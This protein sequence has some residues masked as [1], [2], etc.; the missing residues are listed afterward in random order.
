M[1]TD[2]NLT[3]KELYADLVA[4]N[5]HTLPEHYFT[6]KQYAEDIGLS[7][8]VADRLL[9]RKVSDGV[10]EC[11]RALIDGHHQHIYWFPV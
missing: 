10:L 11:K 8:G 5:T 1:E 6:G 2:N 7:R 3:W 4:A 9:A